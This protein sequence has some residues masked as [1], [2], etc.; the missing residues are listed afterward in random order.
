MQQSSLYQRRGSVLYWSGNS[1][2]AAASLVPLTT[3]FV[4]PQ[5]LVPVPNQNG[6]VAAPFTDSSQVLA[7]PLILGIARFYNQVGLNPS[8]ASVY[9]VPDNSALY[10]E[11]NHA[12]DSVLGNNT[13]LNMQGLPSSVNLSP[14]NNANTGEVT[15]VN[16][17]AVESSSIFINLPLYEISLTRCTCPSGLIGGGELVSLNACVVGFRRREYWIY[18]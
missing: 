7:T 3:L 17:S 11:G 5:T 1:N 6:S 16:D 9:T 2:S 12:I 18:V 4:D 14:T 13:I 10:A 8:L 15:I